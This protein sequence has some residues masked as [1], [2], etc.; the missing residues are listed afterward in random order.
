[1]IY[2][3]EVKPKYFKD[4]TKIITNKEE[5]F[6]IYPSGKFP[7]TIDQIK[8]LYQN[9]KD[10]TLLKDDEKI[11]GFANLYNY[12]EN[13]FIF[14]GNVVIDSNYRGRGYGLRLIDYMISIAKK[15]YNLPEVR[16]SVF[17]ENDKA[18][19]LYTKFGFKLYDQE[20]RKDY[21]GNNRLLLHMKM[22]I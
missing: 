17:N 11:I 1:M 12:L 4:M 18:L 19:T 6:F 14:I 22:K 21:K 15:K 5:L 2:Y 3:V 16:I 8:I 13:K 10:F 9:R 7:L 20:F